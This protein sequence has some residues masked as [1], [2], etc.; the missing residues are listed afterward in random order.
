MS[1]LEELAALVSDSE[2][3]FKELETEAARG[4]D[5]REVQIRVKNRLALM[6]GELEKLQSKR[7]DAVDATVLTSG[8][9]KV[10]S[11]RKELNVRVND[12]SEAVRELH[13]VC[14]QRSMV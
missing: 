14:Q 2:I 13:A 1:L 11:G 8:K 6:S 3:E 9:E 4:A 12:L 7:I 10:R 5:D